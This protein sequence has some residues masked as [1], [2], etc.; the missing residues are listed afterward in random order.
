MAAA[1]LAATM[2]N[3]NARGSKK[4]ASELVRCV[5]FHSVL[6]LIGGECS[7]CDSSFLHPLMVVVLE[8]TN[9]FCYGAA[10]SRAGMMS[11]TARCVISLIA[12]RKLSQ[13]IEI[14]L[15]QNSY[16]WR[17]MRRKREQKVCSTEF[18]SR[19]GAMVCGRC[20]LVCARQYCLCSRR[21]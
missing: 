13:Q 8:K 15:F 7:V 4:A 20:V 9:A 21:D 19:P 17:A 18:S 6:V 3:R 2:Q 14:E 11:C 12:S 16:V 5:Q 1:W 10:G